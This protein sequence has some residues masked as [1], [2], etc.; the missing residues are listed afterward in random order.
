[1]ERALTEVQR[2]LQYDFVQPETL[3]EALQ[4]PGSG[5]TTIGTRRIYTDGNKR[6]ALIG[7]SMAKTE[8]LKVWW[9]T[10]LPRCK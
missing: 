6:M 10:G 2:I 1:M 7:D 5:I 9:A 8:V 4:A 3:W